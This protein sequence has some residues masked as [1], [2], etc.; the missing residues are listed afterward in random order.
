[1]AIQ[2]FCDLAITIMFQQPIDLGAHFRSRLSDLSDWQG[3]GQR[4]TASGAA[5]EAHM[6]L[7]HFS[8]DQAHILDERTQKTFSFAGFNAR[9][10]PDTWKICRQV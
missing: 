2:N 3:L 6:D 8:L 7:D 4:E 10:T 9:I 5:T 1:L